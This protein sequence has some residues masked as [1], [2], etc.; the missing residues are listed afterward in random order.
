MFSGGSCLLVD[1]HCERD[2]RTVKSRYRLLDTCRECTRYFDEVFAGIRNYLEMKRGEFSRFHFLSDRDLLK[3]M[4]DHKLENESKYIT[5]LFPGIRALVIEEDGTK[6]T[7]LKGEENDKP[8]V[9]KV[10]VQTVCRA[11]DG[12]RE[13]IC[14]S[15]DV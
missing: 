14:N 3:V 7:A 6:I 9:L 5:K 15:T 8:L 1:L 2:V 4:A 11:E 10:A 13:R 12:H